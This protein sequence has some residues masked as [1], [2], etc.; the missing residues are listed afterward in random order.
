MAHARLHRPGW[1]GGTQ[2]YDMV[3][4]QGPSA[5]QWLWTKLA[6]PRQAHERTS[7]PA[8]SPS[9]H[10]WHL[11]SFSPPRAQLSDAP[12]RAETVPG[13]AGGRG[14]ARSRASTMHHA[15][16]GRTP[17]VRGRQPAAAARRCPQARRDARPGRG[18][19][20]SRARPAPGPTGLPRPG[21]APHPASPAG[22]RP[23][24]ATM[25]HRIEVSN[26]GF[27]VST[28]SC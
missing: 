27:G 20:R 9:K 10:S 26:H 19:A 16:H 21:A 22:S 7:G 2:S 3:H 14:T 15:R 5:R 12:R 4:S 25:S 1:V 8:P 23:R 18:P 13:R 28:F 17:L 6:E 24:R 11:A